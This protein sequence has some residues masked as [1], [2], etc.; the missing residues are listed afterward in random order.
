MTALKL[1]VKNMFD[2]ERINEQLV[3]TKKKMSSSSFDYQQL[4]NSASGDVNVPKW[5]ADNI[6]A[7][8]DSI[9]S[10]CDLSVG[11]GQLIVS[12]LEKDSSIKEVTICDN[13]II[14]L[15]AA[16]ARIK[17]SFDV[18]ITV[19]QYVKYNDL[20]DKVKGMKFDGVITNPPFFGK[21]HPEHLKF[22]K[23]GYELSN[24]YVVFVQPSTYLVD[25]K[26]EN[27]YYQD[28]RNLVKDNLIDITL[29]TK[30]IFE[31]AQLNTGVAGIV[32]DKDASVSDYN[33]YYNNLGKSV[34]FTNIEDINIFA[35]NSTYISIKNKI[36]QAASTKNLQ[37]DTES[38]GTWCVPIPK[39]QRYRFL[40][41]RAKVTKTDDYEGDHAAYYA[42]QDLADAAYKWMHDPVAILA[43]HIF[44][45]DMNIASGRNLRS[46]PS[47]NTVQDFNNAHNKIGLT[48][49]EVDWCKKIY[50]NS[51]DYIKFS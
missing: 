45:Q 48:P 4:S 5:F 50:A 51:T 28:A 39:L 18:N 37:D 34:K 35:S 24:K 40:P 29:Y 10:V 47:F 23:L 32:V 11:D 43:L 42:T 13:K 19:I 36:L 9:R 15:E 30:D 41:D 27:Q 6:V 2:K 16:Y 46:V 1:L 38:Q 7:K 33:V 14:N 3:I 8:I 17:R 12:L 20:K 44:K 21:G 26:K 49:D 25:N 31:G 22:L